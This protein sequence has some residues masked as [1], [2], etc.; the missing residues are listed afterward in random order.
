MR[1]RLAIVAAAFAGLL[2]ALFANARRLLNTEGA[3]AR[4]TIASP[5]EHTT[6]DADGAV[7]SVQSADVEVPADELERLWNVTNLERLARTYWRFLERISLG[8]I[9]IHYRTD[10][11]DVCLF[12]LPLLSL[13]TFQAPEYEMSDGRGIVQWQIQDG[14][15]VSQRNEGYLEIDVKRIESDRPGYA[16][17][18]VEVEIANFYPSIA[19]WVARWVY[20]NT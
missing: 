20:V 5:E 19:T 9:Q 15:L 4:T 10:G 1:T 2:V 16:R 12:G 3:V 17:I 8:V 18:H 6:T 7:K 11:R 13:L 14:L